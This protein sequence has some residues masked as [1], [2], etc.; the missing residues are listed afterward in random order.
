MNSKILAAAAGMIAVSAAVPALAQETKPV[1]LSLRAG[2]FF[3]SSGDARDVGNTWFIGGA[4]YKLQGLNLGTT[5]ADSSTQSLSISA[6]YYS[7]SN[8]SNVP[9]LLNLTGRNSELFYSIG[10]GL[11]FNRIPD[12]LGGTES[13]VRFAGQVGVGY[14]F[15]QGRSPLFVEGKYFFNQK[16]DLNGFAVYVGIH[17]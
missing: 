11:G 4:E 14:D 15:M 1:G 12:G 5:G 10:A 8:V 16:S 2:L 9:V 3:P 17:L 6:D 13:R 7:K